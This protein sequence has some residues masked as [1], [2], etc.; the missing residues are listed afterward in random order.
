MKI[1]AIVNE[2]D[3]RQKQYIAFLAENFPRLL[4]E[5]NPDMFYVVGGDGSMLHA[6]NALSEA[7][8]PFFGKGLGTLNFVMNNY[9]NDFEVID[10][11]L[12]GR[13]VPDVIET[14]KLMVV[15]R[16][17]DGT[18]IEKLAINDVIIGNNVMDWHKFKITSEKKSFNAMNLRGMGLCIST[19]LGS[20][21]FNIN[22]G[23]STLPLEV[24]LVS[25]TSI[26]CDHRVNEIMIPQD[27]V[28]VNESLRQNPVVYIDGIAN[29]IPLEM[30]DQIEIKRSEKKFKLAFLN[31]EDF[32]SKRTE[33]V[34]KKR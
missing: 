22:N 2:S 1:R 27:I 16:K 20:T 26:V 15:I 28:I 5:E 3:A 24:D 9:N 31:K 34:Q 6:H 8:I 14:L 29:A 17:K 33:L 13:I 7:Q 32:F 25:I 30:N 19:P 10:G 18:V 23:G 12:T 21:S 11:L 4:V